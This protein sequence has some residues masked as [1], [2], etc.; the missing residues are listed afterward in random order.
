MNGIWLL[1][2]ILIVATFDAVLSCKQSHATA[3]SQIKSVNIGITSSGGCSNRNTPTCTSLEQVNCNSINCL[4]VLKTSSG[5]PI[6]VTGGTEVGHA[7]GTLSHYNG[8]KID[9]SL[10]SCI[11]SYITTQFTFIG[12]RGD[13]AA[14]YRAGSGNVYAKE[15]NH[16]DITFTATC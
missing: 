4:K 13:G 8:Y 14:Q 9:I 16:W 3:L 11:N 12:N 1:S 10:N 2:L 5:C 7:G 15:G 6:T